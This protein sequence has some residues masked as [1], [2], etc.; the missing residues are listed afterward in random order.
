VA[1]F[2]QTLR[3]TP[4]SIFDSNADFQSDADN[5]IVWVKRRLGDDVLSVEL[6]KKMI[7]AS[8][9]EAALEYGA[10][11]NQYQAKSQMHILLGEPTGSDIQNQYPRESLEFLLRQ[12]EPYAQAA[13][14][15][16]NFNTISGS[17]QLQ[18]GRQDYDI[19]DEMKTTPGGATTVFS[20]LTAPRRSK[21][22]IM[23][24]FHFNPSAAFRFFDS[25][26]AVN[27]LSNEFSFESFTPET[28]FY[29][30]PVFEDILRAGQLDVSQRV[31]RSNFSYRVHGTKIRIFPT[32]TF[33]QGQRPR[34]LW[35]R[36]QL[37]MNPFNPDFTDDTID[38]VSNL[39]DV[40]F[41]NL[42]Y[43]GINSIGRQWIRQYALSLCMITLGWVRNK[44]DRVPIPNSDLNLNGPELIS[45]GYEERERLVTQFREMLD[46]MTYDKLLETRTTNTE[47]I[48][49]HLR[50]VPMPNGKAITMA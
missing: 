14:V 41:N 17:I 33:A 29:V 19:Y 6:T 8:F 44:F 26:S 32:P 15:G 2:L 48:M 46:T 21:M 25:T 47:N 22:R 20:T 13:G 1:T 39:S 45:R 4:F 43:T 12:A 40:P 37:P 35:M 30:L 27:F 9:E 23:E 50:M 16:G 3:P 28:I 38:G 31:R 11:V 42:D 5:M 24:V 49:K 7:W 18:E 36:V 10:L 34:Y